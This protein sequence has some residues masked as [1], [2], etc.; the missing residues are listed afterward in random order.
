[1]DN[2][3][4]DGQADFLGIHFVSEYWYNDFPV[5]YLRQGDLEEHGG[6]IIRGGSRLG[7]PRR[8]QAGDT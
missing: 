4:R 6:N 7:S 5:S 8:P 2:K 1:M 3:T